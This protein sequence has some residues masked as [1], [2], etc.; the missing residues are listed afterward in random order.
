[1]KIGCVTWVFSAYYFECI[2]S[3]AE[4]SRRAESSPKSQYLCKMYHRLTC[5]CPVCSSGGKWKG[6]FTNSSTAPREAQTGQFISGP[7]GMIPNLWYQCNSELER[8]NPTAINI[9]LPLLC[10]FCQLSLVLW[11]HSLSHSGLLISVAVL[12][13]WILIICCNSDAKSVLRLRQFSVT[14][15]NPDL[16]RMTDSFLTRVKTTKSD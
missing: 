11:L 15:G 7:H 2:L 8:S 12:F 16:K 3:A 1:M 14:Q 4:R 13:T 9:D 10:S 5:T 6:Q